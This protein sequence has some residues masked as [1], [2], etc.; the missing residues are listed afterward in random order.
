MHYIQTIIAKTETTEAICSDWVGLKNISLTQGFSAIPL[1]QEFIDDVDELSG[2]EASMPFE[3][4]ESLNS[5]L[6][7]LLKSFNQKI[8]TAGI[9]LICLV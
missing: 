5:N 1:T 9:I 7:S 3:E 2:K 4:F 6:L 8:G